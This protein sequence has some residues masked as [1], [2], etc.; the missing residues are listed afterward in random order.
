M[1]ASCD[2]HTHSTFSDGTLSP[3][4]L[5]QMAAERGVKYWALT[6]HDSLEGLSEAAAASAAAGTYF[7][8]GV[9]LTLDDYKC[10]PFHLLG[11]GIGAQR[12]KLETLCLRQRER[13]RE[14]FLEI[15][16]RL[17]KNNAIRLDSHQ[18]LDNPL[19]APG[20][21]LIAR[22][23]LKQNYGKTLVEIFHRFLSPQ[24]GNVVSYEKPTLDEALEAIHHSGALAFV[25]HPLALNLNWEE[26]ELFLKF[27]KEAGVDGVEAL[28]SGST[29]TR[30]RYLQA[31]ATRL[32]LLM[33]G[34]SDF[35]GDGKPQAQLGRGPQGKPIS[36]AFLPSSLRENI[37][38]SL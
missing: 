8:A 34:G 21:L 9:E 38:N 19:T 28:H 5:A 10:R 35:H 37:V 3:T 30:Q 4:Q 7:I 14:R 36:L 6:D 12:K 18:W 24:S 29:L 16:H 33:C 25:A 22:E 31:I 1:I 15:L 2:L 13:R 11:L 27:T 17:E 20:R 26:T 32:E 23:L